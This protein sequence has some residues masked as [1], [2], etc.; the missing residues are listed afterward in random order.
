MI[1]DLTKKFL[2]RETISYLFFGV[3]ATVVA[4]G[5]FVV[6]LQI[7]FSTAAGNTISTALAV[8]FAFFTNKVFVFQS[9]T[10]KF[11]FILKEFVKFCSGRFIMFVLET[12]LLVLLVDILHLNSTVMKTFTMMLVIA[13]NYCFSKW[14]VFKNLS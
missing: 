12:L 13:G 14:V 11:L 6:L 9:I 7:G 3:L 2:N 8:L 5:S 10:W 4:L 1:Y